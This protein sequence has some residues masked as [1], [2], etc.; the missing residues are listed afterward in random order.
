MTRIDHELLKRV[1]RENIEALC[2]HFFANGQKVN[3]EW[4]VGNLQGDKGRTLN[5]NLSKDKAGLFQ[6]FATGEKGDFVTAIKLS[7]NLDFVTAALEIGKAVGVS[8]ENHQQTSTQH[9]SGSRYT[10]RKSTR[11]PDWDRDYKLSGSDIKELVVWRGYSLEFCVWAN[12]NC[13]IGR[14]NGFWAFPVYDNG[15]IVSAHIR[16]DKNDWVYRPRL[17][18]I[19]VQLG[20][21]VIGDLA[22]AEKVFSDES[23]WD[24]FSLLDRLGIQHGEAIAGIAT[25]GAQNGSLIGGLQIKA[26]L[27]LIPQ[28]DA[29]GRAWL[30]HAAG[31]LSC[32]V[33]IVT[34]PAI[35]HDV[36]EWLKD[37]KDL[38]E[39]VAA[40]RRAQIRKPKSAPIYVEF[41]RPSYFINYEPPPDLVLVGDNHI[42]RG[43][44]F[45]IG[46]A[47][48]VGK[49]RASIALALAGALQTPWFNLETH[50]KFRTMILQAENGRFRLKQELSEIN[51][52]VLE[53]H[54]LICPPPPF[55][56]CFA[57]D[58]FR[59]QLKKANDDFGPH[60]VLLDPWNAVAHDD[61]LR[62]Y[63][64]SFDIIMEVFSLGSEKGP[65]IG[66]L[67]HT[68]KPLIGERASGR[69]LLNLLAGSYVLGSVPRCV[70][71]MQSASDDVNET[72][73]IWTC[74][75]NNDGRLGPRSVWERKNGLFVPMQDFDWSSF[76]SPDEKKDKAIDE[77]AL[78]EIFK[79]G[80]VKLKRVDAVEA[81]INLTG[82]KRTVCYDALN[83]KTGKLK[84][85][86]KFEGGFLA[87]V[88]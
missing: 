24:L 63:R 41:H 82:R 7:H 6:D 2:R 5:I 60:L 59:D 79:D 61:R 81:L 11:Q 73:I 25:R 30:E 26:E 64:E 35:Y 40:I 72:K 65:A 28:N 19:G 16:K 80:A 34:V 74:C 17:K 52:P 48:G 9:S 76:D 18:D 55:G 67:P 49:S 13:L 53:D 20:P 50:S 58:D 33:K 3:E 44:V 47:P 22:S 14:H 31:V 69:A 83:E 86:L 42:V 85:W 75:K 87:Y 12:A 32:D 37:L 21:L 39:F 27:Y 51:Q 57:K 29:A 70:F 43:S 62:D 77:T 88:P 38:T 46:G 71:V 1:I 78:A 45:V 68:R 84:R 10:T 36:D 15:K 66:I 8:L 56:L 54:L 23:Q 4:K